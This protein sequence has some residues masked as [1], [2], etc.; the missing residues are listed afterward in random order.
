VKEPKTAKQH[1]QK[2]YCWTETRNVPC[3]TTDT[4][5][6]DSRVRAFQDGVR[7]QQQRQ[8]RKKRLS[9]ASTVKHE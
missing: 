5:I 4:A 6:I 8:A 2:L 7:W 9:R 1:A 3:N